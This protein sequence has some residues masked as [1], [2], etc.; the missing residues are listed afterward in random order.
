L[1]NKDEVPKLSVERV[2]ANEDGTSS[3]ILTLTEDFVEWFKE[4]EGLKR[5]SDKRF[6]KFFTRA[7]KLEEEE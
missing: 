3:C 7:M 5:W 4:Q 2:V 6:Q 1:D